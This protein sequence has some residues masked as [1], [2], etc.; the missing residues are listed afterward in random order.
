MSLAPPPDGEWWSSI[1]GICPF[2]FLNR[3]ER[4][5]NLVRPLKKPDFRPF[6]YRILPFFTSTAAKKRHP[7]VLL[8]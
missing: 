7:A 6:F 5:A 8:E 4:K 2:E 3:L 1:E